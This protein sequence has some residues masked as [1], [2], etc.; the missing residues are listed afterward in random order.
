MQ[1]S[2]SPETIVHAGTGKRMHEDNQALPSV[3]SDSDMNMVIWSLMAI[4][5]DASVAGVAFNPDDVATYN[6]VLTALKK[7]FVPKVGFWFSR[8]R[9]I[10]GNFRVNQRGYVSG[11][12]TSGA[13]QY[14]LDRWRVVTSGQNLTF[15]ASGNGFQVT[16]PAGGIEQVIE[17]ANVEGGQYTISWVGTATCTINGTP[18]TNGG[19]Y[20]LTAGVNQTVRFSA[21][22]VSLVQLEPGDSKTSF[23]HRPIDVELA[24]CQRYYESGSV[25]VDVYCSAGSVS[26][27]RI[28]F[29]VAKR[30]APTIS[31]VATASGPYAGAT[32]ASSDISTSGFS[33]GRSGW[34]ASNQASYTNTWTASAEF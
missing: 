23:D 27:S 32:L 17:G 30:V 19:T 8:N 26:Q 15:A 2:T 18:A 14:T 5:E 25:T 13:N 1:Y 16:A 21:G 9:I 29:A 7:L 11:A 3:V 33:S 22:T 10:N 20:T 34:I 6:R 12:A 24:A 4:L 31:Q 28:G